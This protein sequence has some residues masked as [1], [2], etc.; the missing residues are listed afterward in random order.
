M[1]P[2]T[3]P[4]ATRRTATRWMALAALVACGTAMA[5]PSAAE[6][7]RIEKLLDALAQDQVHQFER[8]TSRYSGAEAARFLRAKWQAKGADITSAEQFVD[9]I[10]TRSSTTGQPYRVC[11]APDRCVPA[12][13]HLRGVMR[14]W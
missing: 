3:A 1:K 12:A 5:E 6:R 10:A 8:G 9:Q 4:C 2:L 11:T 13:E 7:A 14:G